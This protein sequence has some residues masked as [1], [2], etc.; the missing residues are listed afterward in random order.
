MKPTLNEFF[1]TVFRLGRDQE[2]E[3]E[4]I[5]P[6]QI[7]FWKEASKKLKS[8]IYQHNGCV[9]EVQLDWSPLTRRMTRNY[10]ALIPLRTG[11][12]PPADWY[13]KFSRPLRLKAICAIT[14][15]N[16]RS[17]DP[18]YQEFFVEYYLYE[19]F[20]I[21]NLALPGSG[22]FRNFELQSR[23]KPLRRWRLG[24]SA[25]YFSDWMI[26]TIEGKSPGA[27]TLDL[28]Q[29]IDWFN[30]VNPHVTQKAENRTQKALYATY[31]LC[32]S[33][34]QIDFVL[35]LFN[36]LEVLLG[37]K[38]GDNRSGIVR[39]ANALLDLNEK[40]RNHLDK[41]IQK[42]YG[43]RSSFV[44]GGYEAPHPIHADSIDQRLR[45][46][47]MKILELGIEGFSILGALLQA[48][49]EKKIPIVAFEERVVAVRG[50]P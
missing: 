31:Q 17:S 12:K 4:T 41:T 38:P 46:D 20:M 3:W 37:T 39:R 9:V 24:L 35:W 29:T 33:D 5:E 23:G 44:H 48:L 40:Q 7:A 49:I 27:K 47:Y 8:R 34:G 30:Q 21:T 43:L 22:E 18:W 16:E 28:D 1:I 19:V 50:A 45:D 42:L 2:E 25:Y 32:R 13:K 10:E 6:R 36:A 14:N 15:S 26:Q 11:K